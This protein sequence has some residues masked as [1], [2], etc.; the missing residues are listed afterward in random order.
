ML[1]FKTFLKELI[2]VVWVSTSSYKIIVLLNIVISSIENTSESKSPELNV[3]VGAK[4]SVDGYFYRAKIV[5]KI[6]EKNYEIIFIDF[7]F[8][9]TVNVTNIVTLPI[10]LQQ[11]KFSSKYYSQTLFSI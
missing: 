8:E 7:G 10:Q 5:E 4:S 9:E 2:L 3:I 6:D 11:V 1:N